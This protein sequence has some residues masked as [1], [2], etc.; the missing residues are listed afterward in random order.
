MTEPLTLTDAAFHDTV[1]E[2]DHPVLVDF[3][4]TS[5]APCHVM[6]PIIDGLAVKYEKQATIA[7]LDVE[8]NPRSA[9]DLDVRSIPGSDSLCPG[10]ACAPSGRC[11]TA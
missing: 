7:K 4:A 11:A 6:E 2:R 3:W 1:R 8:A 9:H 10:P 5:C